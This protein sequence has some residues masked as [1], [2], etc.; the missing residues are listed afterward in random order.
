MTAQV[1]Y[2][3]RMTPQTAPVAEGWGRRLFELVVDF[4][5][6]YRLT[7][8][9]KDDKITEDLRHIVFRRYGDPGDEDSHKI[10]Y[11]LS[12]HGA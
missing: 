11:L 6:I 2:S 12:C 5:A 3:A 7:T 1:G 9:V 10:S 8:L 4:L